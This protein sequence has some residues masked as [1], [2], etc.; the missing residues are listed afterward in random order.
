LRLKLIY[1][2]LMS[3]LANGE[4]SKPKKKSSLSAYRLHDTTHLKCAVT[5]LTLIEL[6]LEWSVAALRD[7]DCSAN[8]AFEMV[9]CGT[10]L[11]RL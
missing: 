10:N 9:A 7:V 8:V 2:L 4:K 1:T 5:S 6:A 3:D 11:T